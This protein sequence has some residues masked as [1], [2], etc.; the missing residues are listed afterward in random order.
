[1]KPAMKSLLQL[2]LFFGYKELTAEEDE[3]E[4]RVQIKVGYMRILRKKNRTSAD[5]P[6][7]GGGI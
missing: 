7:G 4:K 1:M 6:G 3:A 5:P 2:H